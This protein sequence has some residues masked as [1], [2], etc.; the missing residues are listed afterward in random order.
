MQ[1]N[2]RTFPSEPRWTAILLPE[3]RLKAQ[4]LS[5]VLEGEIGNT[6]FSFEIVQTGVIAGI[7]Q[8]CPKLL[9]PAFKIFNVMTHSEFHA[10]SSLKVS[11]R[12]R[13]Y[14]RSSMWE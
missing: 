5:I 7:H 12:R 9:D 2:G 3:C 10:D 1:C 6:N 14:K 13:A 4:S 11:R 8:L